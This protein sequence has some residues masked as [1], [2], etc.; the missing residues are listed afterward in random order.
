VSIQTPITVARAIE[1]IQSNDYVLPAI[2]R[3]FVWSAE[4]IEKLFDSLMRGYPIG[5]FL[6]WV[7]KPER[8]RDFQLYRFMDYFHERDYR[9]NEPIELIGEKPRIAILDGQQRLTALN[10]GLKG[11]YA[12]KLPYYRWSNDKAYPKR[13]LFLNLTAPP[14]PF[15]DLA[16]D[17]RMLTEDEALTTSNGARWFPVGDILQFKEMQSVYAYCMEN[18]LIGKELKFPSSALVRLWEVMT[19][20]PIISYFLEEEQDLDKVL[21]IFIR[22]NAGGTTLSYS[23]MLLSIATAQWH[24][25]DARREVYEL[26]DTL[27]DIGE[28]FN[29]NK[30]FILKACLLLSDIKAIEF[31]ANSFNHENM[32]T[33]QRLWREISTAL[34]LTTKLVSSW[35]YNRD[36]L[37]S[38]NAV[39]PLAYFI[40]KKQNPENIVS[41]PAHA[42]NRQRMRRWLMTALL[43]QTFS[44]QPDNV[45]RPVR[46]VISESSECFPESGIYEALA[47]S[48]K[49]MAFDD[50]QIEALLDTRYGQS[51]TFTVLSF[52]YPWLKFDQHF[53]IDHIFPRSLLTPSNLAKRS[54][55]PARWPLFSEHRDDLGN[56]Q[57]LQG[58]V[59]QN[60]ADKEFEGWLTEAE[61]E[62]AGLAAYKEQNL[63][64]EM[65]LAFENFP[66]FLEAR[67]KL[68]KERLK[69]SLLMSP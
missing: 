22:V 41:S 13:R 30:D 36:T 46:Q 43:K 37:V 20:K 11:W 65:D 39:L 35:G 57:L 62:P 4:Q 26:V 45:F 47:K 59:N 51:N 40:Y 8:L 55:P 19:Q 28:K 63:I 44:G 68:I 60:K 33:I 32:L 9:H 10:I 7:V 1:G 6:F 16:F 34:T 2:Q 17:F 66:E 52:L 29:F 38:N 24:E 48:A 49:S 56:L 27:N 42:E 5:S 15:S 58:K 21:N 3:E 25:L 64:P 23:D 31:K 61:A 14:E 67:T 69:T 50:N 53:H 12:D 54:I 18:D